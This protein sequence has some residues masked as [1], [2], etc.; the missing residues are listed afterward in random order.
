MD[1]FSFI[2]PTRPTLAHAIHLSVGDQKDTHAG[3][4]VAVRMLPQIC[5]FH[6][7]YGKVEPATAVQ[8]TKHEQDLCAPVA[9]GEGIDWWAGDLGRHPSTTKSQ[10]LCLRKDLEV[11]W[12]HLRPQKSQVAAEWAPALQG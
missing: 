7:N 4:A 12:G 3:F 1:L 11:F 9:K 2:L 5:G 6:F 10:I 8:V